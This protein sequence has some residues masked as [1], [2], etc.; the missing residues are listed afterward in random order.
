MKLASLRFN[1]VLE[2][3][4]CSLLILHAESLATDN[5]SFHV[6]LIQDVLTEWPQTTLIYTC[7]QLIL[8]SWV[9]GVVGHKSHDHRIVNTYVISPSV[10]IS[11][12][13]LVLS[14]VKPFMK[15]SYVF[16]RSP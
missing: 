5:K 14:I 15:F 11:W 12:L 7:I 4:D 9:D 16:S 13:P 1:Q 10:E 3:H 6:V 8:F 2:K